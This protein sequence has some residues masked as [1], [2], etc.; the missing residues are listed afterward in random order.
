MYMC[1]LWKCLIIYIDKGG[2]AISIHVCS[3]SVT[4]CR[5]PMMNT[6]KPSYI[7]NSSTSI[8]SQLGLEF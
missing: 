8:L 2:Y 7:P 6:Y 3:L 4:S 5:P 1:I